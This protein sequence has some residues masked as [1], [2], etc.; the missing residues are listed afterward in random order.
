[1]EL[2]LQKSVFMHYAIVPF[3]II[4]FC[5]TDSTMIGAITLTGLLRTLGQLFKHGKREDLLQYT[6][7]VLEKM[8]SLDLADSN[9][10]LLRK[11]RVKVIQ[12]LGLTF[13]QYRVAAWR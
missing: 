8:E 1:M 12:R 6:P 4:F 10:T 13:L 11:M 3:L 5:K 7:N 2:V 9:N